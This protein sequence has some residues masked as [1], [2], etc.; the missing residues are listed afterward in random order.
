VH[1]EDGPLDHGNGLAFELGGEAMW[2][3]PLV[4]TLE[5]KRTRTGLQILLRVRFII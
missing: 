4:I 5:M 3:K 1:R 2:F